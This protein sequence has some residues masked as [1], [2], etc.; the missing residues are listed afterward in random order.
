MVEETSIIRRRFL[1]VLSVGIV[2]GSLGTGIASASG[3]GSHWA[4]GAELVCTF[5]TGS[6]LK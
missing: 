4:N 6:E 3:R 5:N 1:K 2:S